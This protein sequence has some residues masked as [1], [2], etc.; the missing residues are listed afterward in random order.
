MRLETAKEV[1]RVKGNEPM[2]KST[3]KWTFG[4]K[5]ENNEMASHCISPKFGQLV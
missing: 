1:R 5:F 2:H 4:D 3:A